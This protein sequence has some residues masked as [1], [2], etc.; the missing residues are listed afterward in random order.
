MKLIVKHNPNSAARLKHQPGSFKSQNI[1]RSFRKNL[2]QSSIDCP[3][4]SREFHK[5]LVIWQNVISIQ[6][7]STKN[8]Y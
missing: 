8:E 6:D 4:P 1:T 3:L 5:N 7:K 2:R